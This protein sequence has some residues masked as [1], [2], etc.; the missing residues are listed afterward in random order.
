MVLFCGFV[1]PVGATPQQEDESVVHEARPIATRPNTVQSAA[2]SSELKPCFDA[3]G[4]ETSNEREQKAVANVPENY[5]FWLTEDAFYIIMPEEH[6][7]FLRLRSDEK[8]MRVGP[9]HGRNGITDTSKAWG[10]TSI[11]SC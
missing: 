3:L 2:Q 10:R 1:L 8:G 7:A 6:C 9:N 11:S 5:R 4:G